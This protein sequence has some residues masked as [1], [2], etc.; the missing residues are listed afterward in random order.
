MALRQEHMQVEHHRISVTIDRF[1][2]FD[3]R[4]RGEAGDI[5]SVQRRPG[6]KQK[7]RKYFGEPGHGF[8]VFAPEFVS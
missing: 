6:E 7:E 2:V 3:D 1:F 4:I 8:G 5:V